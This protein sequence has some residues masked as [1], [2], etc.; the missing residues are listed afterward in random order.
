MVGCTSSIEKLY[1]FVT[2]LM[3]RL[4]A[5]SHYV[6]DFWQ[7]PCC[8]LSFPMASNSATP[9]FFLLHDHWCTLIGHPIPLL[10]PDPHFASIN[11][12]HTHP[13]GVEAALSSACPLSLLFPSSQGFASCRAPSFLP[14]ETLPIF[15][16][17]L[18]LPGI[19]W[20]AR[21]E[22]KRVWLPSLGS[23]SKTPLPHAH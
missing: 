15:S 18:A 19:F 5:L 9:L 7:F 16:F 21:R 12:S 23:P 17:F 13:F 8:S 20:A 4:L 2:S 14:P 1:H 22:K 3:S 6:V 11:N 10:P